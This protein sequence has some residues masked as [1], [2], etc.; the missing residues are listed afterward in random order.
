MNV[1]FALVMLFLLICSYSGIAQIYAVASGNW[2]NSTSSGN[3]IWSTDKSALLGTVGLRPGAA[4]DVYTNGFLVNVDANVTCKNLFVEYDLPNSITFTSSLR[5]ITITGT[6]VAWDSENGYEEYPTQDIFSHVGQL[7]F[8]GAN[9]DLY[10]PYVVYAWEPTVTDF[11]NL[12]FSF[13]AGNTFNIFSPIRVD[14]SSAN[15]T[16]SISSG[17]LQ[18]DAG[19]TIEAIN[20]GST[21]VNLT[22]SSGA[23]LNASGLTSLNQITV[24]GTLTNSGTTSGINTFSV[25]STGQVNITNTFGSSNLTV[26]GTL[27]TSSS[28]SVSNTLTVNSGASL[29]SSSA[30]S[31]LNAT[32]AGTLSTSSSFTTTGTLNLNTGSNLTTSYAGTEGWWSGTTRPAT[33]NADAA[34]TVTFSANTA[35][36]VYAQS[37]GNLTLSGSGSKTVAGSGTL[38]ITGNLTVGSPF[39]SDAASGI[40]IAGTLMTNAAWSPADEVTFN[41]T[42]TQQIGGPVQPTFAGG[43]Q[44]NKSIGTL[45]LLRS[46]SISNGLTITQGTFDARSYTTTLTG[47]LTNN[48]TL[49]FGSGASLGT[50]VINGTTTVSGTVPSFGHLTVNAASSFSSTGTINV[51]GNITNNGTFNVTGIAL[52]GTSAQTISGTLGL[53][54]LTVRDGADVSNLGTINMNTSGVVTLEGT[55]LF[56]AGA[57]GSNTLRLQSTSLSNGARI[58]ALPNPDR[59]SG[60]V[61]VE[62]YINSPEDWRYLAFPVLNANVGMLKDDFPVTG[63]FSDPSPVGGNV[64]NSTSPSIY[65]LN[66]GWQA[67]GSGG[68][69]ASTSLS[70]TTGYSVWSYLSA[71]VSLDVDG[72][73]GKGPKGITIRSGDNLIPNPYPSAIDWDNVDFTNANLS[74]NTVYVRTANG[75]YASYAGGLATGNHPLGSGWG[76]QLATG[77]S[78]WVIGAGTGT[79]TFQE[80]DKTS[81][82]NFVREAEPKDYIRIRLNKDNLSDDVIVHFKENATLGKDAEFD[83]PKKLNDVALNL[84]TYNDDPAVDFAINGVP[85][86]SCE[87][88]TKLKLASNNPA[89]NYS[90]SFEDISSMTTGYDIV[91]VDKFLERTAVIEEGFSYAFSVTSDPSSSGASRFE[92]IF[93]SAAIDQ[94]REFTIESIANCDTGNVSVSI[95]NSEPGINYQF[96][97]DGVTLNEPVLGNGGTITTILQQGSLTNGL[98]SLNLLA[99]SKDNCHSFEYP[100]AF[101]VQIDNLPVTSAVSSTSACLAGNV[102]LIAGGA[103]QNGFYNWYETEVAGAP[104]EG[105]HTAEFNTPVIDKTKTYYVSAVN[106][107]GCES[108]VR[109][110]MQA[111]VVH[112]EVPVIA[113]NSDVLNVAEGLG[114]YQWY[115]DGQMIEGAVSNT[116][117]VKKSGTYSVTTS[118]GN[119]SVQSQ[120]FEYIVSGNEVSAPSEY[121]NLF[122]NPVQDKLT[123]TGPDLDKS[124]IRLFDRAGKEMLLESSIERSLDGNWVLVAD[125][126]AVRN[127]VYL[128]NIEKGSQVV[129]LKVVKR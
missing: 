116:Y 91:L 105:I 31:A 9:L 50:L 70:N 33:L 93:K 58:A 36:N 5:R 101:T 127:G 37:Y 92:I 15:K 62:R 120:G 63:N 24:N 22:V 107:S 112:P 53:S 76:G 109:L 41:G 124:K 6:L 16:I 11:G 14:G 7:T 45:S 59:F 78:F 61:T 87:F 64:I 68:T 80:D 52:N 40:F 98:H 17:T 66:S 67:V 44:V 35:Q 13:G 54:N 114:Y 46:I 39:N 25:S 110:P 77:Q 125:L 74:T 4:D 56:D 18:A 19:A 82:T 123:L 88:T 21:V 94:L 121:Y 27:T 69:V 126:S 85:F 47:A 51:A 60:N 119:C 29:N 104:I 95:Q 55:A 48:G 26:S 8:T 2:D 34:S 129:Q 96:V 10:S 108:S 100:N 57:G 20:G 83:A 12:T 71:G 28:I 118:S 106:P 84:S 99:N 32:L 73:V 111:V 102:T 128:L 81:S 65:Y 72:E 117:Q 23:T 38:T 43:L 1:R 97:L 75:Q 30:I 3:N 115:L 42:A 90:L 86:I 89:A 113:V 49:S 122:P 79:L 103:P